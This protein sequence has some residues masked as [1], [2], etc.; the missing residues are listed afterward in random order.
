M[1]RILIIG[2]L[3]LTTVAAVAETIPELMQAVAAKS[4]HVKATASKHLGAVIFEVNVYD[5]AT[6]A[7]TKGEFTVVK[8]A[9]IDA[10]I[11]AT[12]AKLAELKGIRTFVNDY[13]GNKAVAD[14][15]T[16]TNLERVEY[17]KEVPA[18]PEEF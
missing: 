13:L 14:S 7:K 6:G 5:T 17:K 11:A 3:L 16:L 8:S 9:T 4:P 15:T 18:V 12:E 1:K 2:L 10:E